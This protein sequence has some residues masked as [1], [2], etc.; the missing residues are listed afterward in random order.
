MASHRSLN[1]LFAVVAFFVVLPTV[2]AHARALWVDHDSR[3]G[4][5]R[6]TYTVAENDAAHPWCTRAAAG[7]NVHAGDTVTVRGGSYSEPMVCGMNPGCSGMC[8]LELVKK[9]TTDQPIT[10]QA[11][12]GIAPAGSM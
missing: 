7:R 10:Y 8:V 4:A 12:A 5:C 2:S 11:A 6:D 9:G 1:H 3:G